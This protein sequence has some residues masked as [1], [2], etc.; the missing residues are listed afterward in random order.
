MPDKISGTRKIG[1]DA[2]LKATGKSWKEWFDILDKFDRKTKGH[3]QTAKYLHSEHK[4][5]PWWSQMVTVRYE[6]EKGLREK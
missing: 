3:T 5:S 4:L 1:D 6:W 2:V